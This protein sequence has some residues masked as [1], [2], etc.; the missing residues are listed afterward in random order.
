M[1]GK[2]RC[3]I[4]G[5]TKLK[6]DC[7][8]KEWGMKKMK[9]CRKC[10]CEA[11][12][13]D[14]YCK[15]CGAFLGEKDECEKSYHQTSNIR[16]EMI[17]KS[18]KK[19]NKKKVGIALGG[20]LVIAMVGASV[21]FVKEK[22]K[23]TDG[24][25]IVS[26]REKSDKETTEKQEGTSTENKK[27]NQQPTIFTKYLQYAGQ[28]YTVLDDEF[29]EMD[30]YDLEN[31]QFMYRYGTEF[32]DLPGE[33]Y[34]FYDYYT[35]IEGAEDGTLTS[36]SW[37][38]SEATTDLEESKQAI[39][40]IYGACDE[41]YSNPIENSIIPYS[42]YH[43]NDVD[44]NGMEYSVELISLEEGIYYLFFRVPCHSIDK[45]QLTNDVTNAVKS[46][47]QE[48]FGKNLKVKICEYERMSPIYASMICTDDLGMNASNLSADETSADYV[49][50]D[51]E[52]QSGSQIYKENEEY[53]VVL[54]Y[55]DGEWKVF[56][57][58][59]EVY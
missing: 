42:C 4:I 23:G 16:Q 27:I 53:N 44:D 32:P 12:D 52:V 19:S 20:I 46:E 37:T 17:A 9:M 45:K 41:F 36:A 25:K 49:W 43:W 18:R 57:E 15:K 29:T 55:A 47:L 14:V 10:G 6:I 31:D 21:Y 48:E 5:K 2:F 8:E 22:L 30:S 54:Y 7:R 26:E 24:S 51:I 39:E 34:L 35:G 13:Q 28:N 33:W 56:G 1:E 58:F 3:L 59:K 40:E 50:M 38:A 11:A